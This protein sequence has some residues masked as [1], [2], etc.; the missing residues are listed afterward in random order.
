MG[1]LFHHSGSSFIPFHPSFIPPENPASTG[2]LQPSPTRRCTA[3]RLHFLQPRLPACA[4][5][6]HYHAAMQQ[7]SRNSPEAATR[8]VALAMI[9]D[10]A[11]VGRRQTLIDA[12]RQLA[13]RGSA[14]PQALDA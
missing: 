9:A 1:P 12:V 5:V 13:A 11:P 2:P 14:S 6:D 7:S 10:G 3:A 4:A 8:L